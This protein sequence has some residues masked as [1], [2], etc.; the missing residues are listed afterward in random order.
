LRLPGGATSKVTPLI[1][2]SMVATTRANISSA[3]TSGRELGWGYL[4]QLDGLA[5]RRRAVVAVG[6]DLQGAPDRDIGHIL[7]VI[8]VDV[9]IPRR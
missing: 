6:V 8:S 2:C 9:T 3:A 7:R 5:R 1:A 4:G